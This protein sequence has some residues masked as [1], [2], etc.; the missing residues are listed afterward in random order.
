MEYHDIKTVEESVNRRNSKLWAKM[1]D[2]SRSERNREEFVAEH[3]GFFFRNGRYWTWKSKIEVQNGYWLQRV[4]TEEKVFFSNM[5]QFGLQNGLTP[6]K[7][8]ELLNGKRKTYKGWTAVELRPVKEDIG[9]HIK[10]KAP[11]KKKVAVPKQTTFIDSQTNEIIVVNNI[12]QFAK[13]NGMDP[14]NLYKVS[15][16]KAKSCNNLRLFN[17]L[18]Q[19]R[20]SKDT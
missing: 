9:G 8:C 6:V 12:K 17:P 18:E 14:A 19:Y 16:G 20:P 7:I 4:D 5:T 10:A 1:N 15:V 2:N 3:G 13:D 11:P